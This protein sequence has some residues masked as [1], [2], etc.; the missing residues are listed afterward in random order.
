MGGLRVNDS[1]EVLDKNGNII[2]GLYCTGEAMGGVIEC[3]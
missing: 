1:A 2:P 3:Y